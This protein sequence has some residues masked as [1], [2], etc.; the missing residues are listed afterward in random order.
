V[1]H[2]SRYR[3][4]HRPA[5]LAVAVWTAGLFFVLGIVLRLLEIV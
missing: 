4:L 3:G 5:A 2:S 1:Y